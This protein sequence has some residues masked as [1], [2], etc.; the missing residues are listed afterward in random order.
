MLTLCW[1]AK[2]G[3]GT[4]VVTAGLALALHPTPTI[5]VD[6]AGDLPATLGVSEPAS[7]GALDWLATDAPPDRLTNLRVRIDERLE[8]LPAGHRPSPATAP[9]PARWQLLA[10]YLGR[11]PGQVVVDAGTGV[12]SKALIAIADRAWLVTRNCYLGLLAAHRQVG[13]ASAAVLVEEPGRHVGAD[14]VE[15]SLGIPVA[16]TILQ[17]PAIARAADAGLLLGR[18]PGGLRRPL[19]APGW[20]EIEPAA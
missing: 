3:S 12:P 1:A 15:H 13:H 20:A 4:T 11:L 5:L 7:P 17:D 18:L 14:D 6:L 2:G 8:L 19:T 10:E 16:T 9:D